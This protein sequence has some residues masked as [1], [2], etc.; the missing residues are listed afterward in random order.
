DSRSAITILS[1]QSTPTHQHTSL[2]LEF[3]DLK[4]RH[5]EVKISHVFREAN[6][7]ADYLANLGHSFDIDTQFFSAPDSIL[8][9]WLRY[10][11]FG[12]SMPKTLSSFN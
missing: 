8:C 11:L 12:V 9:N 4:S 7:A 3:Q 6:Y 5:W 10:D 1:E 2:V